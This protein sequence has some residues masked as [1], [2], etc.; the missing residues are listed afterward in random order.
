MRHAMAHLNEIRF[1]CPEVYLQ[2]DKIKKKKSQFL[3]QTFE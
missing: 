2:Q 1:F 3:G